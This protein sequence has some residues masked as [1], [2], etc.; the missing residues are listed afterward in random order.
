MHVVDA[1]YLVSQVSVTSIIVL[2]Y[3]LIYTCLFLYFTSQNFVFYC[4]IKLSVKIEGL[5]CQDLM[6]I[7]SSIT[8][9]KETMKLR[10]SFNIFPTKCFSRAIFYVTSLCS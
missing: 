10:A 6:L 4:K 7:K 9:S 2:I 5:E 8:S 3:F 1:M